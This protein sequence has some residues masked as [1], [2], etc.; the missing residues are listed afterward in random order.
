[1]SLSE[2]GHAGGYTAAPQEGAAMFF[3]SR[4]GISR[5]ESKLLPKFKMLH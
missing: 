2:S 4:T 5:V 1:M 3:E